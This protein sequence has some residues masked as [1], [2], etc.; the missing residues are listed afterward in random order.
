MGMN[1]LNCGRMFEGDVG[2]VGRDE[3]DDLDGGVYC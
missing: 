2:R 3:D 1:Y